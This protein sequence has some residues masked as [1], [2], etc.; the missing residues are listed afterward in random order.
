MLGHGA[1]PTW[2]Q[3]VESITTHLTSRGLTWYSV[4]HPD[5]GPNHLGWSRIVTESYK[6]RKYYP[7]L[8]T[9]KDSKERNLNERAWSHAG[10]TN[11]N[12]TRWDNLYK[13]HSRLR[14]NLRV[15]YE[16]WRILWGRQELNRYKNKYAIL[17]D[18]NSTACSYCRSEVETEN[19]LY[20]DCRVTDEF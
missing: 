15:K 11:Y 9:I 17:K 10:L 19:H 1:I 5:P 14:C 16:E 8:S 2:N 6:A 13:N 4:N 18:G 3:M 12:S 7:L 20:N